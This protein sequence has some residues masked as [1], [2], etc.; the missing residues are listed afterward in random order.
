M[1]SLTNLTMH[2]G[3]NTLFENVSLSFYSGN[4]YGIVGANG[5]GKSTLLRILSGEEQSIEGGFSVPQEI[6]LGILQQDHF[7]FEDSQVIGVVIQGKKPLWEALQEKE[8]L[9]A[10]EDMDEKIGHR[11]GA[12]EEII[13][14]QDGYNA[15][16]FAGELLSGLGIAPQYHFGP[17]NAL[18][19]GFKLRVLLA[20][21]LF[22]EPDVLLLDEPTN[23]LDILSIAW[24]ENFLK[25]TFAGT[26][27]LVSHDRD[28]LNTVSTHIADVDYET[29]QTYVGNY[30]QFMKGKE[31]VMEQKYKEVA[32]QEKKIAEMQ[33]FVDRFRAKATKARQA[34]SRVKQIERIEVTEIKQSSRQTP[35][36]KFEAN[37]PSG[38]E[39]VTLKGVSK[40]FADNHVL[41]N[42]NFTVM[43]DDK[44]A[45][46]GPN[47]IG[48]STL[49]KIIVDELKMDQGSCDWGYE[50]HFSYFAQDHKTA[51]D[52]KYSV[53]DWLYQVAPGETIGTI[54]G[55]L[56]RMLFSGDDVKKEVSSLSG[57]ERARLLFAKMI[58]EKGNVLIFDEPTNHM[59][60]EGVEALEDALK[61]FEG[62]LLFVTHD[63]RFVSN[64][65]TR[66]LIL[67]PDGVEDFV[68]T[69]DEY[70]ESR[71]ED[72]L[73]RTDVNIRAKKS[74][75]KSE[76]SKKVL[77][78]A[79]R[80]EMKR[81][82]AQ[83]SKKSTQLEKTI[84]N[85]ESKI[86][87]IDEQFG[88]AEF[89]QTTPPEK[90]QILQ[91]NKEKLAV[92]LS[93][94]MRIWEQSLSELENLQL[95]LSEAD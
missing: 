14:H 77:S 17:M 85:Q 82:T 18:S 79:E 61:K 92:Q 53:Y 2:Y 47:G 44:I 50:T 46:I 49:L 48:K 62:T 27:L 29:I 36:I 39:V 1:I 23:H 45:V 74:R 91:Q 35:S 10:Q 64:V 80:K 40:S 20:Q 22:Q 89:Y 71:G 12:L 34:Q 88:D 94:N 72:F 24:L 60:L 63:R 55:L 28:F 33:A 78:F 93:E 56:G 5:S 73:D 21:V 19:G 58:L 81:L 11:L 37:R 8:K 76:L 54:R 43:R 31:L 6:R 57:G 83:L 38:K 26:L 90:I 42:V 75:K 7:Q 3:H 65:A 4:R 70:L 87:S 66:I 13:A 9:L 41:K 52:K 84:E 15:E 25:N 68:G 95:Q 16:S 51:F 67:S 59:D 86:A 69:Y 32:N 30:D